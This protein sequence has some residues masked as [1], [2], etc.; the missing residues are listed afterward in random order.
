M[1]NHLL[2]L[3]VIAVILCASDIY[4]QNFV[5]VTKTN[6]GQSI[7]LTTGQV[8]EV[9][10]PRKAATG[11][12]WCLS[13]KDI[14]KTIQQSIS[15]IGDADFI[16]DANAA[17]FNGK[18]LLGQS[19]NQIIRYVG[20]SQGTTILNFELKRQWDKNSPIIDN[21]SIT[22][23]SAGKYSGTYT[24]PVQSKPVHVT[25]TPKSVP[26][27][28]D[29]RT[30]CTPITDQ[31]QCGD[32][33]AFATCATLECNIK[34]HDGVT[35]DI[36]EEFV[37]DCYTGGGSSGCNGGWC[38]HDCWLSSFS[39]ANPQGGGAVYESED[40]TNCPTSGNTG[41][42]GSSCYAPHE[43][44]DSHAI[45]PN[46]DGNGIPPDA[47]MKSA[48]YNYGPIWIAMDASSSSFNNYSGG[49][50]T[51]T[52]SQTDHAVCLVGWCDS[53]SIS[54]GGYWIM[55]NS[56]STGWGV[57]GYMY[58]SY[59]SA[60]VGTDADYIVYKGGISHAVAP[61]AN[62][63]ASTTSSC[64]GTIQFTDSS[65]NSPS[66]WLWNFGDGGT[67]TIQNPSHTYITSG[68]FTVTLKATNTYGN[69]T[70]TKTSYITTNLPTAPTTTG[71]ATTVGGSVTLYASGSGTL[72]WFTAATGG[73]SIHTG[74]S[75]TIS[76]LPAQETFYVENDIIQA[77]QSAGVSAKTT[78][79][80]YYY[81]TNYNG[82]WGL[83]FDVSSPI[84][85]V[86][87]MVYANS[88]AARTIWLEN[89]S[90][91]VI[92]S[93]VVNISSGQQT[94]TL[95]FDVPVGTGYILGTHG[96]NNLW[97]DQGTATYPYTVSGVISI[98]GNNSTTTTNYYYFYNWQVQKA[99]CSSERVSVVASILT[100][101]NEISESN[102]TVYPNPNSGSFDV[103][104]NDQNFQNAT[105]SITN[106]LGEILYE[107]KA[108][109]NNAPI[110]VDA[111]NIRQG[112]YYVKIQ[113][114][115]SSYM[116][117]V[118]ITN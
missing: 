56:W 18:V 43:T 75:Y 45:V 93:A 67:S 71:G 13:T 68:T 85:I 74:T 111:T 105:V 15:Q 112:I 97:R 114:E 36:S 25:S 4:G 49:I 108:L 73:T 11:Y 30:Q 89:S 78:S 39:S 24:P 26:S 55:R 22:V 69:N 82:E 17:T 117:K 48:I 16:H 116:R 28:W 65:S 60:L 23:V 29:W 88:A 9:Q 109:N 98:T 8:L 59:G 81:G 52:G 10:L 54:G 53:A 38:A 27:R 90:G 87:V 72:N 92:D 14:D 77:A 104:L 113:T 84:R 103:K 64:T 63:G 35:R 107:K 91:T 12:T 44:I 21:Y 32:C 118:L 3:F 58:I 61:V 6:Q 40:A 20:T 66:T 100:G 76:P 96:Q 86:S 47:D 7:S 1:K 5:K 19:G 50:W 115:N 51:T 2:S 57:A 31:G 83:V 95:N 99:S 46:E 37:T 102:F 62:F 70:K 34:I 79:G 94:V 42:C 106:M 80:G 41:T 101:I 110:H 33:W